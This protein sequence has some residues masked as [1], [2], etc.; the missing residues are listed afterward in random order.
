MTQVKMTVCLLDK[1]Q[2]KTGC[3]GY[4]KE[5]LICEKFSSTLVGLNKLGKILKRDWERKFL[6]CFS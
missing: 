3:T 5:N 4:L 1:K 6:P 2:L